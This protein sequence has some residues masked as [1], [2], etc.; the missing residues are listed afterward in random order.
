MT[1]KPKTMTAPD[2]LDDVIEP[3]DREE[4]DE[5]TARWY[6]KRAVMNS[7]MNALERYEAERPGR[8][9]GD[10]A[11][12]GNDFERFCAWLSRSTGIGRGRLDDAQMNRLYRAFD[13]V[14]TS[15]QS[16]QN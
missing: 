4:K 10:L 7:V 8:P 5:L 3:P 14:Y 15:S 13:A 11:D 2:W 16:D 6:S 9:W 1:D 12:D